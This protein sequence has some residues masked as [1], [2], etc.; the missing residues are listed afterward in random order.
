MNIF[1]KLF[2]YAG[3]VI[4]QEDWDSYQTMNEKIIQRMEKGI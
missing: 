1:R 4:R 2:H 3:F